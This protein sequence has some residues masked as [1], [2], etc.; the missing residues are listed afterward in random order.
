MSNQPPHTLPPSEPNPNLKEFLIHIPDHTRSGTLSQ[1]LAVRSEH[2]KALPPLLE[3]GRILFGGATLREHPEAAQPE[4]QA[5]Q[6]AQPPPMTGSVML[7]TGESEE[8]V[9]RFVA[10]DVY[11]KS[12]VWDVQ[13]MTVWAF[14]TAVRRGVPVGEAVWGG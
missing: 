2:L 10:E 13:G 1:R 12:G 5:S 4:A 8:E 7:V 6:N 11:A 3:S 14:R 9:R